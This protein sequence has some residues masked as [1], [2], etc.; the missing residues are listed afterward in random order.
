[1]LDLGDDLGLAVELLDPEVL[2]ELVDQR[3]ERDRLAEG[4]ALPLE[5]RHGLV[6][7]GEP[8]TELEEEAR[9]A[10]ARIAGDEDDLA[11]TGLHLGEAVVQGRDLALS[12][13]ERREP[14]LD[15]DFEPRA[16]LAW[17]EHLERAARRVTLDLP[18]PEVQ[19]LEVPADRLVRR[20]GDDHTSG[21]RGLLHAR[22]EVRRV[23]DR[24][25]VHPEIVADPAHD[26]GP[27]VDAD[28]HLQ[29]EAALGLE[30][31]RVIAERLLD[32][33]RRVDGAPRSVRVGDRRA[34]ERHDAAARVLVD[35]ALEPVDLRSD[36]LEAALDDAVHVLRI[37]LLGE[38]REPRHVGEEDRDLAALALE[39]R[40]RLEDLVG[41][42]LGR[43]RR[44][45]W[46]VL[47]RGRR[48]RA[49]RRGGRDRRLR[50]RLAEALAARAAEAR[51]RAEGGTAARAARFERSPAVVAEAV[52]RRVVGLAGGAAHRMNYTAGPLTRVRADSSIPA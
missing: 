2:A 48:P 16:A 12:A 17:P 44:E 50:L 52:R 1:M 41:E 33:E 42:V 39:R 49:G 11:A 20:L 31:L 38:R 22:R 35:R 37:E 21:A 13:D 25:V 45:R 4:D 24:G 18:L 9:L 51:P 29:T 46:P 23:A 27:R 32:S 5:P 34:E 43:V 10:D 30:L 40:A 6:R 7:I 47:G 36:Q 19:R 26:D 15:S 28:P 3:Q 14:A 8:A